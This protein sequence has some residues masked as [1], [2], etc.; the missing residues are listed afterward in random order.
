MKEE[1][2]E[3][4]KRKNPFKNINFEIFNEEN[5]EQLIVD[6]EAMKENFLATNLSYLSITNRR[7]PSHVNGFAYFELLET[8]LEYAKDKREI[9]HPEIFESSTTRNLEVDSD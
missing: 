7:D 5:I 4:T 9:Y 2:N 3:M 1:I 6:L 8:T